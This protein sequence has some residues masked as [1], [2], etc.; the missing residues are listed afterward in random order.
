MVRGLGVSM[1]TLQRTC[2][3]A[4]MLGLFVLLAPPSGAQRASSQTQPN[5]NSARSGDQPS[6]RRSQAYQR[7]YQQGVKD[8][9]DGLEPN[10]AYSNWNNDWERS[11][12]TRSGYR[13]GYCHDEERKTGYY[14][15]IYR[16]Y[17]PPVIRNGYY[18]YN[19]PDPYCEND[20]GGTSRH[21]AH[22]KAPQIQV[23]YGGAG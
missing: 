19:A 11:A 16:N 23:E 13:A 21:P 18:G 3:L 17:G 5:P 15:G 7:G 14:N 1:R 2:W 4:G 6:H 22:P 20:S 9:S 12:D 10:P 8:R